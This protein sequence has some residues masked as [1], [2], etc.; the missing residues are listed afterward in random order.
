[1]LR[2]QKP[3]EMNQVRM[4]EQRAQASSTRKMKEADEVKVPGFPD[5]IKLVPLG[6]YP[7]DVGPDSLRQ[8]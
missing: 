6:G 2:R 5:I 3:E 7:T 8:P 1:M 4:C